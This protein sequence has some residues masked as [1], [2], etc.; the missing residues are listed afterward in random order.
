MSQPGG[1]RWREGGGWHLDVR[2]LQPPQPLVAVL[3]LIESIDDSDPVVL[4]LD[5]DPVMLYPELTERGWVAE[6]LEGSDGEVR[7]RLCRTD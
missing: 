2:G 3:R 4:H 6:P 7:L 1:R 5:R